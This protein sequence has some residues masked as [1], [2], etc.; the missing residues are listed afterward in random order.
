MIEKEKHR[1][2][3][4]KRYAQTRAKLKDVIMDKETTMEDRFTRRDEAGEAAAQLAPPCAT[5]TVAS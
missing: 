4:S 3:L 2:A 1:R 5:I